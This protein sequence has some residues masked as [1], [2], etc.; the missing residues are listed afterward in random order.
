METLYSQL[1]ANKEKL[2]GLKQLGNSLSLKAAGT[3]VAGNITGSTITH[4]DPQLMSPFIIPQ[5]NSSFIMDY[6]PQ[7]MC[8]SHSLVIVDETAD[9]TDG[10]FSTVAEGATKELIDFDNNATQKSFTK[11]ADYIKVSDEMISDIPFLMGQI[12][13]KLR[14]KIKNK[15]GTDFI[16]A[17]VA[18]TPAV[19]NTNLT[20]GQTATK[21]RHLFPS[22]YEG[23]KQQKGYN[24]N[25]WLLNVP[26]YA[27]V[28]NDI[29]A[30]VDGAWFEMMKP[31][32]LPA[33]I[34][35]ANIMALDTSMFP[36]YIYKEMDV[37]IGKTNN[38]FSK[39]LITVRAESR[40]AWNIAGEC[41]NAFY[42]DVIA[43]TIT[44]I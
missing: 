22:I 26:E 2:E 5:E 8:D 10:T 12:Q 18:A 11:Y 25:L 13:N 14:R 16:A 32:I 9:D 44:R 38:D 33:A 3:M 30:T 24:M 17:L 39:N 37:S 36:I 4:I 31:T 20:V 1:T 40:V 43:T 15:I 21:L 7:I 6:F 41:L 29:D 42:D 35:A 34:T 23:M 19:A 28:F 27:K